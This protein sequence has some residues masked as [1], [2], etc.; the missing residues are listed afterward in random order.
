MVATLHQLWRG[1]LR[2]RDLF[3]ESGDM[4]PKTGVWITRISRGAFATQ[5]AFQLLSGGFLVWNWAAHGQTSAQWGLVAIVACTY[6]MAMVTT[7]L[8]L[9]FD[10]GRDEPPD[11]A[12]FFGWCASAAVIALPLGHAILWTAGEY[13]KFG[14]KYPF[15]ALY[16]P[17]LLLLALFTF[18][19]WRLVVVRQW[20]ARLTTESLKRQAAEHGQALA[21]AQLK[22]LQAQIEPHFLFNTLASIQHLVRKDAAQ[23]DFLL[24]QLT[25]YLRQAIPDIRGTGSTLGREIGLVEAYLNI[26]RVRMGGRLSVQVHMPHGLA[27]VSFPTLIVHTLV[28]NAIQHGLEPKTGPVH[29]DV[30]VERLAIG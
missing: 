7:G 20:F 9:A 22:M 26:V 16:F 14:E 10:N 19:L 11:N 5:L 21:Q 13:Q 12:A 24:T 23:A 3:N 6:A 15:V 4:S 1:L 2:A 17:E 25:S 8:A 29:I 18:S 28:E 30:R 27:D